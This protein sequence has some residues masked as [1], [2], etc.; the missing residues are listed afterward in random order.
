MLSTDNELMSRSYAYE[1]ARDPEGGGY[2]AHHPDLE[3]CFAQGESADEAVERLDDARRAW[4]RARSD[5]GLS[6]PRPTDDEPSGRFSL[7]IPRV[8]HGDAVRR[9]ARQGVSLNLLISTA[10][11][12]FLGAGSAVER[13]ESRMGSLEDAMADRIGARL[14]AQVDRLMASRATDTVATSEEASA[15]A[16]W[17]S[18]L[19]V[20]HAAFRLIV[21][22]DGPDDRR[23]AKELLDTLPAPE[24][25]I[26][27]RGLAYLEIDPNH[28]YDLCLRAWRLGLT[29]EQASLVL[30]AIPDPV[31]LDDWVRDG[32]FRALTDDEDLERAK[33][34][35]S[36][37]EWVSWQRHLPE[38]AAYYARVAQDPDAAAA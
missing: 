25:S 16:R 24:M 9:A 17:A 38:A 18:S 21:R 10:L 4:F 37:L 31:N 3:G 19:A 22:C 29:S 35:A 26:F 5:D 36:M 13:I 11:A 8:T 15:P 7:R 34:A 23:M 33:H 2:F 1:L 20:Q 28:G 12:E 14:E 30:S 32:L 6:I 27:F